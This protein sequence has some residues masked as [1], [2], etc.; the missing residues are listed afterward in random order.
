[1]KGKALEVPRL[2]ASDSL[3]GGTVLS[4]SC[5]Q[6]WIGDTVVSL[7]DLLTAICFALPIGT[8]LSVAKHSKVGWAGYA[9]AVMVA[10]A[11]AWLGV[12][13]KRTVSNHVAARAKAHPVSQEESYF[14]RL[15]FAVILWIVVSSL[16][17]AWLTSVLAHRLA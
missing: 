10:S 9:V 11:L 15:Y 16:L 1:L 4:S 3:L 5:T 12:W 6:L 14:R 2:L 13:A 7:W 8:A 17:S